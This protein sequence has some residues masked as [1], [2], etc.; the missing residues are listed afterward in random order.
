M[1]TTYLV[2]VILLFTLG[3]IDLVV[4]VSNDAVNFLNSAIGSKVAN[5]KTILIIASLGILVGA[6]FSSGMMEV[7]RK[8]IFNP[9]F[10]TFEMIMIIFLAVMLT[11]IILL[12]IYNSLGLPTSTTVSIVFELLGAAFI[13]GLIFS[14]EQE[15][16]INVSEFLNFTRAQQIILGIFGSIAVSFSAGALVQYVTRLIFSFDLERTFKL[17]GGIFAGLAISF[18]T[19]FLLVKGAKGSSFL[20]ADQY[21]WIMD[22]ATIINL[23]SFVFWTIVT[24]VIMWTTNFH[25][26]KLV[27][28]L[29][30][31][32]LAMAFAGNDLVNF[33]GVAVAGFQSYEAWSLSGML[34]SEFYMDSLAA[35]VPTPTILLLGAGLIMVITLWFSAKAKKVTETEVNLSRQDEGEERFKPN[36]LSRYIVGGAMAIGKSFGGMTSNTWKDKI[37]KQFDSSVKPID[38]S[39][40]PP[41]FDLLRASVNLMVASILI[42][43]ATSLKLPLSTTY[44]SFMVAMGSSLSDRAWGRESAVYRVA[45]VLNVIGGW[46]MTAIVAFITAGAFGA[47]LYFTGFYGVMALFVLAIF[48]LI[49]SHVNFKKKHANGE[50]AVMTSVP[51]L[52]QIAKETR[53]YTVESI[54]KVSHSLSMN[55]KGLIGENSDILSKNQREVLK[56]AKKNQKSQSKLAKV[57]KQMGEGHQEAGA[58]VVKV[59]RLTRDLEETN[60][61]LSTE[62][63]QHFS[64]HHDPPKGD[65]T[66]FLMHNEEK[67]LKFLG[68]MAR[69]IEKTDFLQYEAHMAER[70][71]LSSELDVEIK[72]QIQKIQTGEISNR[73]GNLQLFIMMEIKSTLSL[74]A[75]IFKIYARYAFRDQA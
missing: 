26:L 50:V 59:N 63:S 5:F 73:L 23:V 62:I 64:N 41:A 39:D 10:F 67:Y 46:F 13:V 55:I 44:V 20:T 71:R 57:L 1:E 75:R 43:W 22:N 12:D 31:F 65:F 35:K 18:I 60:L 27:V 58:V 70:K 19:Y 7:A 16:S 34:P 38:K 40:D 56:N 15:G 29:G 49:R 8:G 36:L 52:D 2:L 33:I 54:S 11:D 21:T 68:L 66:T 69:Q 48:M 42:S 47:I 37:G 4:G 53:E 32:S 51:N 74:S 45:G 28:L 17:Y 61:R 6:T 3:I 25:P 30:T 72:N 14:G 9:G 24:Y